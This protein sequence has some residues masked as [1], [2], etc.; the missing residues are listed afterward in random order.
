MIGTYQCD[1]REAGGGAHGPGD[2][3]TP[4]LSA[5]EKGQ[6]LTKEGKL[7]GERMGAIL[8]VL[9]LRAE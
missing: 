8:D 5:G 6:H 7:E 3:R 9:S 2:R 1:K 4:K